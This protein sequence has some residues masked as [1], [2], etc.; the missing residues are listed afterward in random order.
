MPE[1][2]L[3]DAK[4]TLVD[5][6]KRRGPTTASDLASALDMTDVAVRQHL[7]ALEAAGLVRA[8]KDPPQGRGRPSMRWV[9]TES[10]RELFPDR[11]ADLTLGLMGALRRTF[12]EEG[13]DRIVDVR[14][15][16][17]V[18]RYR[19]LMPAGKSSLKARVEALA[20]QRTVEGY[21]AEIRVERPGSYLLIEHHC[22]ICEA[23]TS[24]LR[25]CSA[26]LEVF[27]RTL[28][29]DVRVERTAH[30]LAGDQ[31]CVY[32]IQSV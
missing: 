30:L 21:M 4:R 23:A 9:L 27:Q 3:S 16:E 13:L 1:P 26:E 32:R 28:G 17:Q 29:D 8:E 22:P 14:A 24:C 15:E 31:R 19:A 11:H 12:G 18:E 5:I 7:Q 2:T 25:L 10:T 20:Q 6:L